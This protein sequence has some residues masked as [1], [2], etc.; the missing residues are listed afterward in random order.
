M[1]LFLEKIIHLNILKFLKTFIFFKILKNY[2]NFLYSI[3][4]KMKKILVTGG[5]GFIGT[6]LI[7]KLLKNK[8]NKILNLDKFSYCS[9]LYLCKTKFKN[10][11]NKKINLLNFSKLRKIIILYKPDIVFHLAAETHVDNSLSN[12]IAIMKIT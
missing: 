1:S 12:P 2:N 9:N 6:H 5:N 3:I 11:K 4:F 7:L 8:K 10:L